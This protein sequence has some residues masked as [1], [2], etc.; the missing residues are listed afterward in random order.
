MTVEVT[1][2]LFGK[3]AWETNGLEGGGLDKALIEKIRKKRKELN[4][5]FNE[6]LDTLGRLMSKGREGSG[7][8]YDVSLFKDVSLGEARRELAKMGQ[9]PDSLRIRG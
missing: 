8:H 9:N 4:E 1:I 7:A 3:S 6:S 2:F 5:S